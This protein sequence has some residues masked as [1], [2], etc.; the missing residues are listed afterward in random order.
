[1]AQTP[2]ENRPYYADLGTCRMC[3][4]EPATRTYF[5]PVCDACHDGLETADTWLNKAVDALW[6][7]KGRVRTG[8]LLAPD[9]TWRIVIEING[10]SPLVSD[11][12][13]TEEAAE[14]RARKVAREVRKYAA[15]IGGVEVLP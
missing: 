6:V 8:V 4:Q 14:R 12:Y 7:R 9:M 11:P 15:L 5:A 2:S 1:M 13:P 3:E 10:G